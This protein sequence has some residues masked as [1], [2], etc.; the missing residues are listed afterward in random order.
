MTAHKTTTPAA[1]TAETEEAHEPTPSSLR[2][3]AQTLLDLTVDKLT[4]QIR[5]GE[6]VTAAQLRV[7][8]D[9]AYRCGVD[10]NSRAADDLFRV[11]GVS[12]KGTPHPA[13]GKGH[14]A[15]LA[16]MADINL[17]DLLQ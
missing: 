9:L 16:S 11:S 17:D 1:K 15:I 6:S 4:A 2:D 7:I 13:A 8:A 14:D 12:T 3:R 5:S 10:F